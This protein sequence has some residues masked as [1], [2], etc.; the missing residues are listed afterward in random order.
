MNIFDFIPPENIRTWVG[1]F[2]DANKF[3]ESGRQ[4]F[5]DIKTH[6]QVLPS[7]AVLDAGCGCGRIALHFLNYLD[8]T[9][10]YHGFDISPQHI[11]WCKENIS[12]SF[13]NF[14][15]IHIDVKKKLYNPT[16]KYQLKQIRLP[17]PDDMFDL[18]VAHSLFTHM[19]DDEMEHY[20]AEFSRVIKPQGTLYASYYLMTPDSSEGVKKGT[21]G[22]NFVYRIGESYTFDKVDPEEGIA[23]NESYVKR[24]YQKF[25][26]KIAEP[27]HYSGWDKNNKPDQDFIISKL[28]IT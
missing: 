27:I 2:K 23:Q 16:G 5:H 24:T 17:Y 6:T 8:K 7:H 20:L 13:H 28:D 22:F 14:C 10:K 1:P 25:N 15:F 3:V 9:G 21:A 19:L 18:I 4:T 26:F 11:N 12:K